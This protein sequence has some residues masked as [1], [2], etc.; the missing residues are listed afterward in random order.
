MSGSVGCH[1][2]PLKTNDVVFGVGLSCCIANPLIYKCRVQGC[3]VPPYTP[4]ARVRAWIALTALL[5][6]VRKTIE[7]EIS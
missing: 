3:R 1:F 6:T 5:F 7:Q 4:L 2:K